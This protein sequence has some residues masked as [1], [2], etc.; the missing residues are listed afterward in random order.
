[1]REQEAKRREEMITARE[2]RVRQKTNE[3]L[4]T[5]AIAPPPEPKKA[6]KW[7]I[8]LVAVVALSLGGGVWYILDQQAKEEVAKNK[9]NAAL[10]DVAA[11]LAILANS[12]AKVG[13]LQ[14]AAMVIAVRTAELAS[15]FERRD[16]EIYGEGT[17]TGKVTKRRVK[18][19]GKRRKKVLK[20]RKLKLN[21]L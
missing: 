10:D 14:L 5:E 6:T 3:D 15:P 8:P 13:R 17:G 7:L 16:S 11:R 21:K 18:R 1:M 20:I 2:A 19:R 12:P 9:K 4:K